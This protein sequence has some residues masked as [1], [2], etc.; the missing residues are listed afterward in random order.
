M[1]RVLLMAS[2]AI[3]MIMAIA[4]AVSA[5]G[6]NSNS[7]WGKGVL[8]ETVLLF[9]E[10]A[11][12]PTGYLYW[13]PS[14]PDFVYD[15]HGYELDTGTLYTLICFEGDGEPASFVNLGSMYP[16]DLYLGV[17]IKGAVAWPGWDEDATVCLVPDS[18]EGLGGSDPWTPD[19]YLMPDTLID[20]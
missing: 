5:G 11:D 15:F 17:H 4:P 6:G 14:T 16:C 12:V 9:E 1:R 2:V 3:A 18:W 13:S 19:E 20:I 10:G 7:K 8:S